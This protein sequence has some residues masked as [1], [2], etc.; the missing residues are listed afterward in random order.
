MNIDTKIINDMLLMGGF[1]L[2][3][4]RNNNIPLTVFPELIS[5]YHFAITET[6]PIKY[7]MDHYSAL[8]VKWGLDSYPNSPNEIG[9]LS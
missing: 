4:L 2:N 6:E 8:P 1:D 5:H 3:F 9:S 7:L